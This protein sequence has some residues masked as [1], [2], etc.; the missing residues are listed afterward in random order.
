MTE[1][2]NRSELPG[3][4][5]DPPA[6]RAIARDA[7]RASE[8][9]FSKAFHASPDSVNINRLRDGA[10]LEVNEG[11]T[12]M[13]GYTAEEVLGRSSLGPDLGIWVCAEDRARVQD[14]LRRED[15][16]Q[17]LE[18]RF[19]RKD[20]SVFTGLMSAALIEIQGE[21]CLLT[22]TRD[23]TDRERI[24]NEF[25]QSRANLA[26]L[27][28]STRDLVWSVDRDHHLLAFNTALADHVR[29]SYGTMASLGEPLETVL[30]PRRSVRLAG[31][32]ERCVETGPF[33]LE[34]P[35]EDGRILDLAFNPITRDTE[36]VGVSVFGKDIT[37]ARKAE[38]A[39]RESTRRL[40]LAATSGSLGIWELNLE[41][42]TQVWNDRM[43]EIYGLEPQARHPDHAY[44]CRHIVHPDDLDATDAAIQ[45]AL[46]GT[47]AYEFEFRV[48]RPDREI[49][50]IKTHGH[51]VRDARGKPIR[52][53]GINRDRTREVEAEQERRRLLLEL[54]HADK[55]DS[56]GSLAGGV[57][58][59]INNVLAAIMGMASVLRDTEP[60]PG[61][62]DRALDA[63]TLACT[64]GRD[65]VRSLLDFSRMDL[66]S[67]GQVDLNI[68][69]ME[70]IQ[71]LAQTTLSRVQLA[72]DFQEPL[73]LIQGDAGAL[74][75]ALINLCV[76]AVDA[77]AD[78]GRLVFRTRNL[79]PRWVQI[80]LEDSGSGMTREVHE[81]ALNPFFTTKPQGK[82][83]G[84]G[85]SLVYSTVKAHRGDLDLQ[86]E[87]GRGTCVRMKFPL[88]RAAGEGPL[89]PPG[90]PG[91]L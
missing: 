14:G 81:K 24:E 91:A 82:G 86:S 50:H 33:H 59:D 73:G 38:E 45:E 67:V 26:A 16:V 87:P 88:A 89:T 83:T 76:N 10:F 37:E 62:R 75:H 61:A 41:D 25:Q 32:Y 80:E 7:L 13:T 57:A 3:A 48:I 27:I 85:L 70:V 31:L 51:L 8:E 2:P 79:E 90:G 34:Y 63:I 6:D 39:V 65:V 5:A 9:K 56:L 46:A 4:P 29:G 66:E 18:A 23:M 17:G 21:P 78:G 64:R 84:L 36:R 55:M 11:F 40:E 30:P 69:V 53:I 54:Q 15:R 72:T 71:L 19:R 52:M 43:Y 12:A 28:E 68:I 20:G 77:M 58:H 1:S 60:D 49:R 35:L 42:G 47:R 44:W 22:I 74:S